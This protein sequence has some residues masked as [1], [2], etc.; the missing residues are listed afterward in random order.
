MRL[1]SA[2]MLL[3]ALSAGRENT[4]QQL[5]QW[6][7][8]TDEPDLR[9]VNPVSGTGQALPG[10]SPDFNADEATGNLCLGTGEA[11]QKRAGTSCR[12]WTA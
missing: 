3:P 8:R 6:C 7:C 4:D 9:L 2:G 5:W 12:V 10:Y 1:Q 11:A